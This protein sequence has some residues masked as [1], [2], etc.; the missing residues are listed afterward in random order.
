MRFDES[1]GDEVD[2]LFS[3]FVVEE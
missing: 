2:Q 3:H 1:G